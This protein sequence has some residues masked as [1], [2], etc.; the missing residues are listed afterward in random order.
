MISSSLLIVVFLS[1]LIF[2]L[3]AFL[4]LRLRRANNEI[5]RTRQILKDQRQKNEEELKTIKDYYLNL[6][7]K[8]PVGVIITDRNG[9]SIFSN[10][11]AESFKIM[12]SKNLREAPL[13]R[14]NAEIELAK[15]LADALEGRHSGREFQIQIPEEKTLRTRISPLMDNDKVA[16]AVVVVE[17][18]TKIRGLEK[19]RQELVSIFSHEL[20]TPIASCQASVET[21]LDWQA[22]REPESRE[23]F[24]GNLAD[25]IAHL[26]RLV[27]RML[28]L[29]RLEDGSSILTLE[30]SSA[31]ELIEKSIKAVGLLAQKRNI[32][33]EQDYKSDIYVNVDSELF[34]QALI[35]LLDN[36]IKYSQPGTKITIEVARD[37]GQVVF[38]I[39]DQGPGI[40]SKDLNRIFQRFFRIDKHRSRSQGGHGLGLALVKH[41][42]EAHQGRIEVKSQLMKGTT[43]RIFLNARQ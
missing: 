29:T 23:K 42:V 9:K 5:S 20:R 35:N 15:H 12:R 8:V 22:D 24:L 40:P 31:G 1:L 17:D 11:I 4:G 27:E 19:S 30:K 10:D 41:I 37:D 7:D 32:N 43:F 21:L 3:V 13:G 26:S 39:A 14:F 33:I 38:V 18:V 25:Q 34:V 2:I 16:G 6:L 36:A 28:Q